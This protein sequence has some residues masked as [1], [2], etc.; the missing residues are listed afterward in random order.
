VSDHTVNLVQD[1]IDPLRFT[2]PV[3]LRLT[4]WAAGRVPPDAPIVQRIPGTAHMR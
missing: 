3:D 2:V 1:P 4:W